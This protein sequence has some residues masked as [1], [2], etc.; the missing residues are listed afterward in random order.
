MEQISLLS[1]NR[2][3]E[4]PIMNGAGLVKRL[5]DVREFARTSL[6]AIV[7]GS[8]T[9]EERLGNSGSVF[10]GE[11]NLFTVN[12]LGIPNPGLEY[13][14]RNLPY[15]VQ[16]A[17]DHDKALIF[18]AAGFTPKEFAI[19]TEMAFE[20]GVDG[21]E[22]NWGCPNIVD[23]AVQKSV[24]S[25]YLRECYE[26]VEATKKEIGDKRFWVKPSPFSNPADRET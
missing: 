16:I 13:Y 7:V 9:M 17:H 19:L 26:I 14:K 3:L 22:Q 10:D 4:H 1:L 18:S 12:S 25:F 15:M 24:V 5:E 21:V 20:S 2:P 11:E 6:S 23:G 8:G